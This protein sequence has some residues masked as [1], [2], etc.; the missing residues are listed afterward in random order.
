[1]KI[2][3]TDPSRRE[4]RRQARLNAAE[5]KPLNV[6]LDV[7][8]KSIFAGQGEDSREALRLL[9]S[10][11]IHRPVRDT[12]ILNC[13]IT[14]DQIQGKTVRLD[15]HVTF[16]DGEQS[17]I[18]IQTSENQEDIK[19]RALVYASLLLS[20]QTKKGGHYEEIKRVYSIF[21]LDFILFPQSTKVP[22]R[23]LPLEEDEH[24]ILN[25]KLSLYFYEMPKLEQF[26]K[27]Y[28]E[29]EEGVDELRPEEKWCIYFR[30]R[31]NE[32]M[33]GLIEELCGKSEGIMKADRVAQK[34]SRSEEQWAKALFRLKARMDRNYETIYL[35]KIAVEEAR[36]V[37]AEEG[38]A[39]GRQE[40]REEGL[41]K[42]L[43]KG[44]E[45]AFSLIEQGYTLEEAR[46]IL[47]K[48]S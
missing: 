41:V 42:G 32:K 21:F 1:M 36:K 35:R 26:V 14:P 20:G 16:N 23:Y 19:T 45:E 17:D 12:K 30:Y 33:S 28:L 37:A 3:F 48:K 29:G 47:S 2:L 31:G 34:I 27:R 40:G 44:Y 43:A 13:E 25:D 15:I 46:K 24:D 4:I 7:V 6:M 38:L 9:L 8:F 5:G 18:E 39:K 11:C 22:R 10:D